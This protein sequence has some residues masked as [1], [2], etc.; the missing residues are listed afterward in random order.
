MALRRIPERLARRSAEADP[1]TPRTVR[2]VWNGAVI[3][4]SDRTIVV[5]GNHYFPPHSVRMEH[6]LASDTHTTC[7]WKGQAS[8][9]SVQ[10]GDKVSR[11]A[12]W[13]YPAPSPAASSIAHHIAFWRGVS[14]EQKTESPA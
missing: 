10:V 13:Y 2:A 7:P 3:A 8:Y 4:E 14:V 9:Y 11:D 5:E 12:A 6:L 1:A